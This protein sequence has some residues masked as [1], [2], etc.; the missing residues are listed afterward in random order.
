[1]SRARATTDKPRQPIAG[2]ERALLERGRGGDIRGLRA[3]D[4]HGVW[5]TL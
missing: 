5:A 1:M 3:R 2:V 4:E